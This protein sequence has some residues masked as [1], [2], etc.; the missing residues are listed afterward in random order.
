MQKNQDVIAIYS[1]KSRFTGK[2]DSIG[3]QIDMCRTYISTN[4]GASY[5]ENA[6]VFEDEGFSGGNINRPDFKNMMEAAHKQQ[7]RAV[8]VYRLDRI[9]RNISD[10]SH[11]IEELG[12]LDI[13]FIS[14]RERFDTSNPMGRAM[15]YI[16]SVFS[17]LERETIAE[18]IR[19]NMHELAKT[20][21]WLGGVTPTGYASEH[22]QSLTVDGKRKKSCHL[23]LIPEEAEIIHKI[24]SLY[25]ETDSL[26]RTEA[27]LVRQHIK[28]KTGRDFTRFSIKSILQNPV[29]LI[30]DQASYQYFREKHADLF[31]PPSA[32]DGVHGILA[33]NRTRQEKGRATI[34][35]PISEWIVSVGQHPGLISSKKWIQIQ[36]SL[37]R[38]HCRA[39]HKPRS[40]TA[41]LTGILWCSCGSRMYPKQ[42]KQQTADGQPRYTYVCKRKE[43]S[44]RSLCS[45][46][47]LNG[48]FI[49]TSILTQIKQLPFDINYFLKQLAQSKYLF[50]QNQSQSVNM[51][52]HLYQ[53]QMEIQRKIN[54]L[55][56]SLTNFEES[57][58]AVDLKERI[59]QLHTQKAALQTQIAALQETSTPHTLTPTEFEGISQSLCPPRDSFAHMS[60][61][62]KR[63][64]VRAIIHKVIWDGTCAHVVLYRAEDNEPAPSRTHLCEDSK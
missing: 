11:L 56:D 30:A 3:N 42:T 29:Y 25:L 22:T 54:I 2:G 12:R 28:T 19:D 1:R 60:T 39:Y 37:D 4:F 64:V 59:E 8:V 13:D 52:T 16:A 27:E 7:F 55:I 43:H 63:A 23:K 32:F 18:R 57:V 15:M 34:Y 33:Y 24:Y 49:D 31:S 45:N 41:L 21:R 51:K 53:A 10:F 35:L 47:N 6:I 20:G 48:N 5:A 40:N 46:Q 62:Q 61:E 50:T 36:Q 38:N 44:K 17:Q 26:T 14:I 9:S 58:A